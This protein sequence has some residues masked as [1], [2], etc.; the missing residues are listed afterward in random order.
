MTDDIAQLLRIYRHEGSDKGKYDY[1]SEKLKVYYCVFEFN[2]P[3]A[4]VRASVSNTDDPSLPVE[5]F[6]AYFLGIFFGGLFGAANQVFD[7]GVSSEYSSFRFVGHPSFW[8]PLLFK[9]SVTHAV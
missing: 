6:R 9:C 5:T 8:A 7:A 4:E 2:S 1:V 3:Y